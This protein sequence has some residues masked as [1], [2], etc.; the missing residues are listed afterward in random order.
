MRK[1]EASTGSRGAWFRGILFCTVA[2]PLLA[3]VLFT[4]R[5]AFRAPIH[6]LLPVAVFVA[7]MFASVPALLS[8]I[9]C[10][11]L[12]VYWRNSGIPRRSIQRRLVVLGASLG[13]ASATAAGSLLYQELAVGE[14]T[15][16]DAIPIGAAVGFLVAQQLPRILWGPSAA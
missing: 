2:S 3:A 5:Y 12:A 15:L 16:H 4:V 8:G 11:A 13:V 7:G 14:R 10:T 1:E 6:E 9:L